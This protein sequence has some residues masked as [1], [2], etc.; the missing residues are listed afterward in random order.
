M[1][2]NEIYGPPGIGTLNIHEDIQRFFCPEVTTDDLLQIWPKDQQAGQALCLVTERFEFVR[3]L[4][5]IKEI[6]QQAK[7]YGQPMPVRHIGGRLELK[8]RECVRGHDHE[9]DGVDH[10]IEAL[11]FYL[12]LTCIE[13]VVGKGRHMDPFDWLAKTWQHLFGT[14]TNPVQSM[15]DAKEAYYDEYG[16]RRGFVR[17]ITEDLSDDVRNSLAHDCA[18]VKLDD[19]QI[20]RQSWKEWQDKADE[21]KLKSL[22][23]Y[24]YDTV[25]S[26]FTHE[27]HRTFFPTFPIKFCRASNNRLVLVWV[28]GSAERSLVDLLQEMVKQ[29]VRLRLLVGLCPPPADPCGAH[30][31]S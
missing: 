5:K 30:G 7:Q 22:A 13:I 31:E 25:R 19:G 9:F 15:K 4:F 6:M 23:R 11:C 14:K 29:L 8:Y 18:L 2:Q 26:K 27:G 16:A 10:D 3:H 24:L 12:L 17:A 28:N 20:N 21:E 1:D